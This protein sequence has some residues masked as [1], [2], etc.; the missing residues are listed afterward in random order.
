MKQILILEWEN[1][2]Q[3]V[4]GKC[5]L[6]CCGGWKIGLSDEEI[7]CYQNLSHPFGKEIVNAIDEEKKCIRQSGNRCPLLTK[8]GW[9]RIV[10]E[11]GEDYL[12]YTCAIFPRKTHIYGDTIE[13]YVEIV[14]PVVA[15]YLLK[16]QKIV[17]TINELDDVVEED[18]DYQLYDTLSFARTFLIALFQTYDRLYNTGKC[19]ILLNII[20]AVKQL[21][22]KGDLNKE[23]IISQLL[24]YDQEE[25][26]MEI[27]RTCEQIASNLE[28]K[29]KR[30]HTVITRLA[31]NKMLEILLFFIKNEGLCKNFNCWLN[32]PRQ[33]QT[34]IQAFIPYF[35][36]NYDCLVENYFVYVLFL[37]W[38]PQKHKM[39]GFGENIK[40]KIV[41]FGL[42]QLCAM[43]VWKQHGKIQEEEYSV[44]I[45][46]IERVVAHDPEMAGKL[47]NL[48]EE[49]DSIAKVLLLLLC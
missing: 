42:I 39:E 6:T 2:F 12:S 22:Q 48:L 10:Q 49:E 38:I 34:D 28:L 45:S 46:G 25:N 5:P 1:Q 4:G 32:D 13:T 41:E 44:I 14:C 7:K 43:S 15:S 35:R 27:F 20:N 26:C 17:L 37:D 9:C 3:C 24:P 23:N 36:K 30:F 21:Y 18:E 29:S 33:L 40:I 11:C 47:I 19:Y 16:P 31:E 8:D